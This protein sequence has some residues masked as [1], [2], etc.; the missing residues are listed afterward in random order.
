M[1]IMK[2]YYACPECGKILKDKTFDI[3]GGF[4]VRLV[5]SCGFEKVI[6]T[7]N[8]KKLGENHFSIEAGDRDE[9]E[10]DKKTNES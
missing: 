9:T 6:W 2:K 1:A 4:Q 3:E 5:C 7:A 8:I 10:T